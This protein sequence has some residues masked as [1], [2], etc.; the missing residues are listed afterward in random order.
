LKFTDVTLRR[1]GRVLFASASFAVFAGQKV[2]ITGANGTG[3]RTLHRFNC[4]KNAPRARV[5]TL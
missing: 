2:G 3:S 1:D 4:L 5:F